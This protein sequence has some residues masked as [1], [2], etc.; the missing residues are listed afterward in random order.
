M[1]YGSAS[2]CTAEERQIQRAV[3]AGAVPVAAAGNEFQQGNPPEFP[4]SLPHVLT[5]SATDPD[6]KPTGFSNESAA[7]DLAAPGIGILTAVPVRLRP[8]RHTATASPA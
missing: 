4:A 7:V 8:R 5:V 6:D 3:K 2:R 1:S